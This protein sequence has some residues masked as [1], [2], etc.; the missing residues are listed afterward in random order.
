MHTNGVLL[1]VAP[2][3]LAKAHQRALTRTGLAKT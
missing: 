3:T 2:A 1:A